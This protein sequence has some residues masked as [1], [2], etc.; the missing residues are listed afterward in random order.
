M[1]QCTWIYATTVLACKWAN[2]PIRTSRSLFRTSTCRYQ[3]TGYSL[4]QHVIS[5]F[6]H[7]C[8][9]VDVLALF[10]S[11][12]FGGL[13]CH[14]IYCVAC[15]SCG[16]SAH[17]DS[18]IFVSRLP[19]AIIFYTTWSAHIAASVNTKTLGAGFPYDKSITR[20]FA[21]T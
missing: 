14:Y 17:S 16:V 12:S 15:Q 7:S 13:R 6:L 5:P 11:A 2:Y 4:F 10:A 19:C 3:C 9:C 20:R 21:S 8:V 1:H 18:V